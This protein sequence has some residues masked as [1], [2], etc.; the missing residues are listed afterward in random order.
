MTP[1]VLG[2]ILLLA[3]VSVVSVARLFVQV[4]DFFPKAPPL[5]GVTEFDSRFHALRAMLP[6][7]GMIGYMTDPETPAADTNAQAEFHLAQYALAPVIVVQS[8]EQRYVVGNFHKVVT[9]GALRDRGFKVIREFG[10]GI[11]L[12]ENEKGR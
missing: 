3:A 6:A 7:K 10:R 8:A 4:A 9:A 1:R 11:V 5:D 12:L 2:A